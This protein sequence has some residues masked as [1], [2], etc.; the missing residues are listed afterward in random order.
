[1]A[2]IIFVTGGAQSG[3]ARWAVS[4]LGALD[5]VMYMCAYDQLKKTIAERIE[6]HCNKNRIEWDIRNNARN[7]KELMKGHKFAILD[8]LG[9]YTNRLISEKCEN[10][11]DIS[12]KLKKEIEIQITEEITELIWE[13]KEINGTLLLLSIE[14]GLCP[15]PSDPAQ[16]AYRQILG[17]IN[18]RIAN[19]ASDVYLLIS[20][21]PSKLK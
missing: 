14:I 8:N 16:E 9:E 5:N 1:M 15:I 20:G 21:I 13:T 10:L 2:K 18:Q 7:L 17:N 11:A 3:K 6:Y 12:E 4:Y 19:Q